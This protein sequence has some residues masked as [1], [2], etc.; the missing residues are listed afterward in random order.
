MDPATEVWVLETRRRNPD[1]GPRRLVHEARRAG[2]DQVPSRSGIYRA[3][4]RAGLIDAATRRHRDRRFR[5]WERGG[6]MELWQMDVVGGALLADGTSCKILTAIDDHSRFVV[7]ADDP[8]HEQGG[9]RPLRRGVAAPRGPPGDPDRQRQGVHRE[10][11][12]A[13]HRGAVRSDLQGERDR[14][15]AHRAP[16]T[17]DDRQDRALPPHAPAWVPHRAYLRRA[18]GRSGRARSVG[19]EL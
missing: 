17:D 18:P 6:P 16:V 8:R 7:C 1:W 15:P 12:L 13:R 5:R 14:P 9:M 19:P 3:L 11:R 10:V 2:L 4:K